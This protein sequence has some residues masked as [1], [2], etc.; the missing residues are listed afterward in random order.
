TSMVI[1]AQ[2]RILVAGSAQFGPTDYDFAVARI[3]P[4]GY[5]DTSFGWQGKATVAFDMGGGDR[6]V[7]NGIA[8]D[9]Q[10]RIVLAGNVSYYNPNIYML[11]GVT[12]LT[13]DGWLDYGFGPYG[14]TTVYF[15]PVFGNGY[16]TVQLANAVAVD[17]Q[18]RIVVAGVTWGQGLN[19]AFA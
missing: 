11:M 12:R 19:G 18:D 15:A 10:G 7:A 17:A 4:D 9:S 6:D 5:F 1:D 3:N 16:Q 8:L 14:R 2:G 13:S